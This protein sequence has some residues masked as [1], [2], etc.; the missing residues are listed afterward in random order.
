MVKWSWKV[1][2]RPVAAAV[3]VAALAYSSYIRSSM[4]VSATVV[5]GYQVATQADGG[6]AITATR[7][8]AGHRPDAASRRFTLPPRISRT[9]DGRVAVIEF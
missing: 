3:L 7:S 1:R 4:T 2:L 9:A 5:N 8:F 6:V